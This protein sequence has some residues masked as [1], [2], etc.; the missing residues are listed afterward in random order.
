[1]QRG[2]DRTVFRNSK[3]PIDPWLP[4]FLLR[5][6][7]LTLTLGASMADSTFIPPHFANFSVGDIVASFNVN[8]WIV[9]GNY[10]NTNKL[11]SAIERTKTLR[12]DRCKTRQITGEVFVFKSNVSSSRDFQRTGLPTTIARGSTNEKKEKKKKEQSKK[13]DEFYRRKRRITRLGEHRS[14]CEPI[15]GP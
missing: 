1:M 7:T 10:N 13:K 12:T 11:R 14:L 2:T 6:K 4:L 9:E 5:G 8:S 15:A 3:I